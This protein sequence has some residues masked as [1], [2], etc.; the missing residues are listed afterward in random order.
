MSEIFEEIKEAVIDGDEELTE[1]LVQ[2]VLDEGINPVDAMEK[3]L[4][5]GIE[6]VGN[7]WKNGE[8]FLPDVMMSADAMKTGLAILEPAIA[9]MGETK[10]SK[11]KIVIG[12]VAGDIHDIGK[13]ICSA[14]LTANGYKV[15]DIGID[16]KP[17]EFLAKAEEVG[18][19]IIA[20]S[21]LLTTT[22]NEQKEL[23]EFL[24]EKNLRDKFKVIV[25]GGPTSKSWSEEIGADGWV[26]TAD[27]ASELCRSLL[28]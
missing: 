27:D 20:A 1:E 15:F 5:A 7:Q 3:G 14:M 23:I 10:E 22:M 12:T 19:Q 6:E 11:G 13:N 26:E 8:A 17:E 28:A 21:A 16:K 9:E 25:G 2:K 24:K 4:I 18:A